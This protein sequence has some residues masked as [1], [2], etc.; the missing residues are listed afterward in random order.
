MDKL[1]VQKL[2]Y[3]AFKFLKQND[4]YIKFISNLTILNK[5]FIGF[6]K[7]NELKYNNTNIH[8]IYTDFVFYKCKDYNIDDFIPHLIFNQDFSFVWCKSKEG[9]EY[10]DIL[11]DKYENYTK[12]YDTI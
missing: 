2:V 3:I 8:N 10:W 12:Q 11:F 9:Y 5:S 1:Q 6:I 7:L 4:A